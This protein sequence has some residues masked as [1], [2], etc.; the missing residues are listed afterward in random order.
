MTRLPQRGTSSTTTTSPALAG[1]GAPSSVPAVRAARAAVDAAEDLVRV[2][3]APHQRAALA[4]ANAD[5]RVKA[6]ERA[7]QAA[8]TA[9]RKA[10]QKV[11]RRQRAILDANGA[12][13]VAEAL[14][15]DVDVRGPSTAQLVERTAARTT[16]ERCQRGVDVAAADL[17]DAEEARAAREGELAAAEERL[18]AVHGGALEDRPPVKMVKARARL[19][20][21]LRNLDTAQEQLVAAQRAASGTR[22]AAQVVP[23]FASVDTFV[24]EYVLPNW[25][26]TPADSRWCATWWRHAEAVTRLE[27][28]WEA[29]EVM[30]LEPAPSLSTWWRDHLD[31][32]MRALT[33][34]EGTF[35]GCTAS[36]HTKV[37]DQQP[38]W[39]ADAPAAGAFHTDPDSPRQPRRVTTLYDHE[40]R[41]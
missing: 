30:R 11:G 10:T 8:R 38:Q 35:A 7:V 25:R 40:M 20:H 13:E 24:E 9:A 17:V 37:H 19:S 3:E 5:P 1:G 14:R 23:E 2:A 12:L 4:A 32:H 16:V 18:A 31:V 29:F 28:V 15:D 22:A 27:A 21:A 36:K 33:A 41:A 39:T 6:A 26:H 34:V